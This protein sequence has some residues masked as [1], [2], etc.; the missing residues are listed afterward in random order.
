[1]GCVL[2]LFLASKFFFILIYLATQ[3]RSACM[4][5]G[6]SNIKKSRKIP[7]RSST[8]IECNCY[9]RVQIKD[10]H[11]GFGKPIHILS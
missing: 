8:F 7:G 4:L 5:T 6:G 1:M 9:G 2:P 3:A 11:R 10:A